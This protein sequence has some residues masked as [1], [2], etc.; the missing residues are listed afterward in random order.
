MKC[1]IIVKFI[2]AG[3]QL[4][5]Q[6]TPS[7]YG[8]QPYEPSSNLQQTFNGSHSVTLS[9]QMTGSAATVGSLLL[10][11]IFEGI[12]WSKLTE[13][14]SLSHVCLSKLQTESF[15]QLKLFFYNNF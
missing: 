6:H 9:L 15:G 4:Q 10:Y 1:Y 11:N 14:F 8:Q 13:P 5:P 2:Y 12:F 7:V 3:Q